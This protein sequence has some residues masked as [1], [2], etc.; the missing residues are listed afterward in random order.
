MF[1]YYSVIKQSWLA[2]SCERQFDRVG[3]GCPLDLGIGQSGLH[4]HSSL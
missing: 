2:L 4:F 3:C 1:E